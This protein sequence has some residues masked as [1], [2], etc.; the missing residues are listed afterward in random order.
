M[1]VT[2][3][4]GVIGLCFFIS[5]YDININYYKLSKVLIIGLTIAVLII[6]GFGK[7]QYTIKGFSFQK[8]K[9]FISG[10]SK[11]KLVISFICALI[12]Y[13]I[14]SFQFY[15]LL[16]VFKIDIDYLNAMY[17]ITSMYLLASII[18]SIFIFDI[19][20]R[21]SVAVYLFSFIGINELVI[22]SITTIMW[23]LNFVLPAI[24]GSYFVL[25]FKLPKNNN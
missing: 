14:F 5:N 23:L 18:P 1:A 20:I 19:I 11:Q 7:I 13:L 24:F 10:F 8:I 2:T 3:L 6:L 21:G 4:F 15:F 12:K 9:D 22:L 16:C 25:N 17:F